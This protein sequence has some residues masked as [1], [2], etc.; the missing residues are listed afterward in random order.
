[1]LLALEHSFDA[2]KDKRGCGYENG[3]SEMTLRDSILIVEE[4]NILALSL[5][6]RLRERGYFSIRIDKPD[7]F[8]PLLDSEDLI[9]ALVFRDGTNGD[10]EVCYTKLKILKTMARNIPLLFCTTINSAQKEERVRTLGLY[11]YH[12]ED[13]GLVPLLA[14]IDGAVRKSVLEDMFLQV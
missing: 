10:F 14:A 13:M 6:H 1:M 7:S 2:R 8:I 3:D 9:R 4:G 5:E 11:Y 12:T